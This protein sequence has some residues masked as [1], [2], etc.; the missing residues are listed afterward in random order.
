MFLKNAG[1]F[2][3]LFQSRGML[4]IFKVFEGPMN[5]EF[6]KYLHRHPSIARPSVNG[7]GVPNAGRLRGHDGGCR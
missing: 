5:E 7:R 3:L 4:R 2:R 6:K 1:V